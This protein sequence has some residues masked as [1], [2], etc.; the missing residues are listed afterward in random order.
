MFIAG[1]C[2]DIVCLLTLS[3]K[4]WT[5]WRVLVKHSKGKLRERMV[6]ANFLVWESFVLDIFSLE[7]GLPLFFRLYATFLTCSKSNSIQRLKWKKQIWYEII[8]VLPYCKSV[9]LSSSVVKNLPANTGDSGD[10]GSITGSGRS[11]A[12]GSGSPL[13]YSC[14][15]NPMVREAWSDTAYGGLKMSATTEWLNTS[16][17]ITKI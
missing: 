12:K 3:P 16:R 4:P 5:F 10:M 2:K 8:F 11:P 13:Q 15:D 6:V 1:P 7:N 17:H 14:P 9:F